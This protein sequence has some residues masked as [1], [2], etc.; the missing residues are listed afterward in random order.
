[1]TV[2]F[3]VALAAFLVE[4]QDFLATNSVVEH[5]YHYFGTCYYRST[6]GHLTVI[7]DKE[8]LIKLQRCT[9]LGFCYAM[10]KQLLAGFCL[11]LLSLHFYDCVHCFLQ[12]FIGLTG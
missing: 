8:Y 5:F 4:H 3:L 7:V 1:M 10:D 12:L 11:E 6:Y 9:L 2:E